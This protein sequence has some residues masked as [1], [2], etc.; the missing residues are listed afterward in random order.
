MV[1]C[2][3]LHIGRIVRPSVWMYGSCFFPSSTDFITRHCANGYSLTKSFYFAIAPSSLWAPTCVWFFCLC[4][5]FSISLWALRFI[6]WLSYYAC[7][8]IC[9]VRYVTKE[10][11]W[12]CV[13]IS[14]SVTWHDDKIKK[15]FFWQL[16]ISSGPLGLTW[17]IC[18][19]S[20]L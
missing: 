13:F 10:E 15:G 5:S 18:V 16:I 17:P 19:S 6:S 4:I 1:V 11:T 12:I 20:L 7:L 8:F 2:A 3:C 14:V 9:K